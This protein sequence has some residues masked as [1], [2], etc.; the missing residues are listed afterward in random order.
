MVLNTKKIANDLY[1]DLIKYEL[2]RVPSAGIKLYLNMFGMPLPFKRLRTSAMKKYIKYACRNYPV[3]KGIDLGCGAGDIAIK[4]AIES[5]VNIHGFDIDTERINIAR[6]TVAKYGLNNEFDLLDLEKKNT[7]KD[8]YDLIICACLLGHLKND[9]QM[10]GSFKDILKGE[11]YLIL[12]TDMETRRI[13][14]NE[15][16]QEVGHYRSGYNYDFLKRNLEAEGFHI[17]RSEFLD[18]RDLC[19]RLFYKYGRIFQMLIFP[20]FYPVI[21][22]GDG[23]FPGKQPNMAV[24][25]AKIGDKR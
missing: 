16:E 21:K 3:K 23:I 9:L 10:L 5:G 15:K 14:S 1:H 12:C 13:I 8:K 2:P 6:K 11:G 4:F 22:I 25:L 7:F 19:N 20:L 18:T 24:F 17:E